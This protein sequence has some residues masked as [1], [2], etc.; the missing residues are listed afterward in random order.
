MVKVESMKGCLSCTLCRRNADGGNHT[1]HT[2]DRKWMLFKYCSVYLTSVNSKPQMKTQSTWLPHDPPVHQTL[3]LG[4]CTLCVCACECGYMRV[5]IMCV[6]VV[7]G[8]WLKE[9]LHTNKQYILF[10]NSN[11]ITFCIIDIFPLCF[12]SSCRA[13]L[14]L[15]HRSLSSVFDPSLVH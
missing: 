11:T 1:M 12:P 2:I 10:T 4:V 8:T 3:P 13:L 7:Y 9:V 6:Y 14:S 15:L 5:S